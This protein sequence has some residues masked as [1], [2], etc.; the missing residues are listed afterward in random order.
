MNSAQRYIKNDN[1]VFREEEDGAFLFD[2]DTGNLKYLNKSAKETYLMLNGQ[3][4]L[5]QVS[6]RLS[7]LYPDA[8]S[9]QIRN[10]VVSFLQELLENSFAFPMEES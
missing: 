1:I 2:P 6:N 10:D 7:E 3:N 4:D 5:N 9:E 8:G